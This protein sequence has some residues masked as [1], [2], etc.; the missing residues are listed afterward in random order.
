VVLATSVSNG[1]GACV[2]TYSLVLLTALYLSLSPRAIPRIRGRG[3]TLTC[4]RLVETSS[5]RT[6]RR[7][8]FCQQE[9]VIQNAYD[10][11]EPVCGKCG[12]ETRGVTFESGNCLRL[13]REAGELR[14]R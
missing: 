8:G 2:Y 6:V 9:C 5:T 11:K 7:S 1:F 4:H 12:G 10:V 3:V 14:R 13:R